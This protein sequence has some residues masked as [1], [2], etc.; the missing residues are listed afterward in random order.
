MARN[1]DGSREVLS[2]V[3]LDEVMG[4]VPDRWY[5][6]PKRSLS[7]QIAAMNHQ[8]AEVIANGQSL[9]LF[10]DGLFLDIN[11][12][13]EDADWFETPYW[14][15]YSTGYPEAHNPCSKFRAIRKPAFV[16]MHATKH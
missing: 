4:V 12:A 6:N 15:V 11:M 7:E 1:V 10:G 14:S 13:E 8:V 5:L 16:A 3:Q 2:S 9:T